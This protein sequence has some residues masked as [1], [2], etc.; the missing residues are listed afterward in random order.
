MGVYY[1][2]ACVDR[3]DHLVA[4][5]I[6]Q[7]GFG[8]LKWG[9]FIGTSRGDR[10]LSLL[11]SRYCPDGC[12]W[13]V[14]DDSGDDRE[15]GRIEGVRDFAWNPNV[16]ADAVAEGITTFDV[17]ATMDEI[18]MRVRAVFGETP[19]FHG[20]EISVLRLRGRVVRRLVR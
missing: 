18:A 9:E 8:G 7:H 17:L 15:Y 5:F 13:R 14:V 11:K 19:S 2:F 4:S 20:A 6:P 10:M 16:R 1:Y 12:V 3:R